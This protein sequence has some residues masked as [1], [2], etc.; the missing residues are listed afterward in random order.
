MKSMAKRIWDNFERNL[1]VALM[2][3]FLVNIFLQVFSR[4]SGMSGS[5]LAD[6]GGLGQI[7][8]KAMRDD[9]FDDD[10]TLGVTSASSVLGPIVPPSVPMVVYGAIANVSVGALFLGGIGPGLAMTVV[11]CGFICLVCRHRNYRQVCHSSVHQRHPAV[12]RHDPG[13]RARHH[14]D[15]S[16]H[17]SA[18]PRHRRP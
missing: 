17:S 12:P 13:S 4:I 6:V 10:I 11:L 3:V 18:R 15:G 16:H 8:I 2:L 5:A 14:D 9:G 1:M 7:E